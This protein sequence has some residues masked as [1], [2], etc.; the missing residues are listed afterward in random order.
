MKEVGLQIY[1]V[2]DKMETPDTYLAAMKQI[3]E[4]GYTHFQ[5]AG[6]VTNI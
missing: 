2:R 3:R 1:T 6:K 5:T 4:I